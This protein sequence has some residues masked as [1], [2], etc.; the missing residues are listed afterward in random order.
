MGHGPSLQLHCER[1]RERPKHFE[2][3]E[4]FPLVLFPFPACVVDIKCI[5]PKSFPKVRE[6][7]MHRERENIAQ[8]LSS[9]VKCV[10]GI[11][12][13]HMEG[14]TPKCC[15]QLTVCLGEQINTGVPAAWHLSQSISGMFCELPGHKNGSGPVPFP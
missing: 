12:I 10:F 11:G 1:K 14:C 9:P 3:V 7:A 2:R 13:K 8:I 15:A 6:K 5:Y 4:S